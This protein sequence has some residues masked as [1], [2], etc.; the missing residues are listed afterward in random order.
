MRTKI[1]LLSAIF[2]LIYLVGCDDAIDKIGMGIQPDGDKVIVFDDSLDITG[3][4]IKDPVLYAKSIY[5]LLGNFYDEDYGE[6][7]AGYICQFFPTEGFGTQANMD[8]IIKDMNG[9]PRI[10]SIQ[11]KILYATYVGDSLSP[12]E[13]SVYQVNKPLPQNYYTNVDPAEYCDMNV[14]LGK[15]AYTARDLTISDSLNLANISNNNYKMVSV[16]LPRELGQRFFD[17]YTKANHG[18]YASPEAM[19]KFFPGLYVKSTFGS[20]CMLNVEKTG[21]YIYYTREYEN[22]DST[23]LSPTSTRVQASVIDVTK[24]VIQLNQYTGSNEEKLLNPENTENMY[25]KTPAGIFA[26]VT[27]PMAEIKEKIG[28]R[29]FSNVRLS[30]PVEPK[31]NDWEYALPFP[32]MGNAS[33][34]ALSRSKLLLIEADSATIKTFFEEKKY[35]D[36]KTSFYTTFDKATYSYT[37]DNIS[38]IVQNAIDRGDSNDLVLRLIPVQVGYYE[39]TGSYYSATSYVDYNTANYLAPSA[40]TLKKNNLKIQIIAADLNR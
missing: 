14:V 25:L 37:F 34:I 17:E 1:F 9:I 21:I 20:G 31:D 5:G 4:T 12:M 29:K 32:G 2:G 22:N 8:S 24:E 18:A 23:S 36:G 28:N 26:Q 7:T 30:I 40:V 13:V 6:L 39:Y 27:I 35:A 16:T 10:D 3:E 33:T 15:Q 19:I 11:L 38:N